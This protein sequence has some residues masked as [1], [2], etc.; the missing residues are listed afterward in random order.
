MKRMGLIRF[1]FAAAVG[2]TGATSVVAQDFYAG[3]TIKI[4]VGSTPGGGYDSY[5]RL[6]ARHMN[7][8]IP[9]QPTSVV[10]NVPGADGIIA[11]N[12]LYNIADKDGT[13]FGT[14]NRY[15]VLLSLLLVLL[16]VSLEVF[17]VRWVLIVLK[18]LLI[19]RLVQIL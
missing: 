9:G 4:V 18:M 1:L 5:A 14:F 12:H 11:A 15:V 13:V 7:K 3:K 2:M 19:K 6:L 8:Y 17:L 10:V 16:V